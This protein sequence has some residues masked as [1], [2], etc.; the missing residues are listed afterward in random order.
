MAY[1]DSTPGSTQSVGGFSRFVEFGDP[2]W[3]PDDEGSFCHICAVRT[4]MWVWLVVTT[5]KSG[6]LPKSCY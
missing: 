3:K 5:D 2:M 4:E 1:E 6:S